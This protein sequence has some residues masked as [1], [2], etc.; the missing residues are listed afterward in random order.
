[1]QTTMWNAVGIGALLLG[2]VLWVL[3]PVCHVTRPKDAAAAARAVQERIA[4]QRRTGTSAEIRISGDPLAGWAIIMALAGLWFLAADQDFTGPM[5][6]VAG[7]ASVAGAAGILAYA[8]WPVR[9]LVMTVDGVRIGKRQIAWADI[10]TVSVAKW[11]AGR[12]RAPDQPVATQVFA[13][14][15]E[16]N[17]ASAHP[18][19][20][21]HGAR[22][23]LRAAAVAATIAAAHD[24]LTDQPLSVDLT[25]R[26]RSTAGAAVRSGHR[27][28]ELN[29]WALVSAGLAVGTWIMALIWERIADADDM[30]SGFF[31][32]LA[33]L[34]ALTVVAGILGWVQIQKYAETGRRAALFGIG[35]GVLTLFLSAA[36]LT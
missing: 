16:L 14:R 11:R 28:G 34:A 26:M 20:L 27:R 30:P 15:A 22:M 23:A 25:P 35:A 5:V 7:F 10:T 4:E 18:I 3:G 9:R 1:M 12:T 24:L 21:P 19:S 17:A 8:P 36:L 13:D 33:V 6:V 2:A 32:V 29:T 31:A